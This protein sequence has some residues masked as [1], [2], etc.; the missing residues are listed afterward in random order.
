MDQISDIKKLRDDALQRL[1]S[2]PDYRTLRA[3]TALID[4]LTLMGADGQTSPLENPPGTAPAN[5]SAKGNVGKGP[6][7]HALNFTQ[8]PSSTSAPEEHEAAAAKA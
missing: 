1:Q 6:A 5:G 7:P 3:L 2:N 8:K 4:D